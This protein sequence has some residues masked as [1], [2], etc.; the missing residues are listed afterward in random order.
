VFAGWNRLHERIQSCR[1]SDGIGGR[2]GS[3]CHAYDSLLAALLQGNVMAV[4]T[5][6]GRSP[7]RILQLCACLIYFLSLGDRSLTIDFFSDALP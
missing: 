4:A 6:A 2:C 7:D 3:L 1:R 5:A